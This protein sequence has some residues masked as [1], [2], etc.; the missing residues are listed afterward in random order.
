MKKA[1]TLVQALDQIPAMFIVCKLTLMMSRVELMLF[2][3]GE[4]VLK[5]LGRHPR[6]I[7]ALLVLV[8]HT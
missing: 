1:R 5:R 4:L 7:V 3:G 8:N 2:K 6:E